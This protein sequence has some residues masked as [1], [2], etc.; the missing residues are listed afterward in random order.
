MN[1]RLTVLVLLALYFVPS[2]P[3]NCIDGRNY[4]NNRKKLVKYDTFLKGLEPNKAYSFEKRYRLVD[5]EA[6]FHTNFLTLNVSLRFNWFED[7]GYMKKYESE[8]SCMVYTFR[9]NSA[10]YLQMDNPGTREEELIY[11]YVLGFYID[12]S[13]NQRITVLYMGDRNISAY[14]D[15]F[16]PL[17]TSPVPDTTSSDCDSKMLDLKLLG[18]SESSAHFLEETFGLLLLCILNLLLK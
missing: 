14:L 18:Y 16:W 9:N 3:I 13:T 6:C 7:S 8:D 12:D 10:G 11:E 15:E 1:K 4:I 5:K 2:F 17:Q